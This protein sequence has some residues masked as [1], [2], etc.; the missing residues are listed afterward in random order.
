MAIL[1]TGNSAIGRD[2]DALRDCFEA[3]VLP[4]DTAV[5]R[6]NRNPLPLPVATS[7]PLT[8]LH[9]NAR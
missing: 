6:E 3:T 9:K 4:M 2:P 5:T 1:V 8:K 7:N